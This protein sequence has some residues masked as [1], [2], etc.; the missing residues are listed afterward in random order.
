MWLEGVLPYE[1]ETSLLLQSIQNLLVP[2]IHQKQALHPTVPFRKKKKQRASH[3]GAVALLRQLTRCPCGKC[4]SCWHPGHARVDRL[5]AVALEGPWPSCCG[6][7]RGGGGLMIYFQ[8]TFPVRRKGGQGR[9]WP[10]PRAGMQ[11]VLTRLL[12]N[13][14]RSLSEGLAKE[15][16]T[17]GAS[18]FAEDKV[19]EASAPSLLDLQESVFCFFGQSC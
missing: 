4:C 16:P 11:L 13:W 12:L 8:S 2:G 15:R 3:A 19:F 17:S 10:V 9:A 18:P 7:G 1:G 6:W 5:G 14:T